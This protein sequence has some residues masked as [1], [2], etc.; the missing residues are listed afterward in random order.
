VILPDTGRNYLTKFF[1]DEWMRQNGFLERAGTARV[2]Q[3]LAQRGPH[4]PELVTIA[5]DRTVG[6]AIDAMQRFGISQ[7][8][9]VSAAN[10]GQ[11]VGS[12]QERNL[13]D[14][15]FRDPGI[16]ETEVGAAMDPPLV[17]IAQDAPVESAFEPLLRGEPAVLVTDGGR[18]VGLV[19]RVDLLEFVAHPDRR[20][21]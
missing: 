11:V 14:R 21:G 17:E 10:G 9:V 15:V 19:S 6:E 5:A 16:V 3:V 2:G 20:G 4:I 12:L 18:P 13:L 7:L 1:S 8:P